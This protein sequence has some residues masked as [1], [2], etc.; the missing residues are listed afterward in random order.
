MLF[1]ARLKPRL[2]VF[3]TVV[4]RFCNFPHRGGVLQATTKV[5]MK[6]A[7]ISLFIATLLGFA[8]RVSDR[9]F[10]AAEFISILFATGL[11]AWTI[12]QYSHQPLALPTA[13]PI[14]PPVQ[15]N[16]QR[17]PNRARRLAA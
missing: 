3:C 13:R 9:P 1:T 14:H 6:T 7:L 2:F 17:L 15:L 10:D 4:G 12:K 11:A 8:S 5:T 16:V